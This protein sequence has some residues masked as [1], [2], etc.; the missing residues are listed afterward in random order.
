MNP[1]SL[2]LEFTGLQLYPDKHSLLSQLVAD[3]LAIWRGIPPRLSGSG[4]P[5]MGSEE[6]KLGLEGHPSLLCLCP[7][8]VSSAFS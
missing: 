5:R 8:S 2:N 1:A 6:G 4:D 7:S 3:D